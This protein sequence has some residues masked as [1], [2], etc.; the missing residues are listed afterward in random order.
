MT[1]DAFLEESGGRGRAAAVPTPRPTRRLSPLI[2]RAGTGNAA[3]AA[4]RPADVHGRHAERAAWPRANSGR[5][6][7]PSA[8][9][10]HVTSHTN[11]FK[12]SPFQLEICQTAE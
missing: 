9:L 6:A 8:A 7:T 11:C 4:E 10:H 2:V 1:G 12:Y 5:A 3:A